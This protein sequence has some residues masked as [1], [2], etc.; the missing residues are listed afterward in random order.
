MLLSTASLSS[1]SQLSHSEP[2]HIA[3][4][5]VPHHVPP[6]ASSSMNSGP[7]STAAIWDALF[8]NVQSLRLATVGTYCA[9]TDQDGNEV[10]SQ[11]SLL[12]IIQQISYE[13]YRLRRRSNSQRKCLSLGCERGCSSKLRIF[14]SLC[15]RDTSLWSCSWTAHA[16]S[17]YPCYTVCKGAGSTWY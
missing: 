3:E 14:S 10:L 2:S 5:S 7:N 8:S 12:F 13:I 11:Y 6:R 9:F 1:R 17:A 4:N 16:P 15:A